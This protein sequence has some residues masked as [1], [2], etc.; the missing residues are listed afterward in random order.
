L[1]ELLM[2]N[3]KRGVGPTA[4]TPAT[5]DLQE[6]TNIEVSLAKQSNKKR[7]KSNKK[8]QR[9]SSIEKQAIVVVPGVVPG[10]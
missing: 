7:Q 9:K 5:K 3:N 4:A 8:S 1:K 2:N 10:Q 6:I